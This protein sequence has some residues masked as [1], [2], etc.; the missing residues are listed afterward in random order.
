MAI[1]SW[2]IQV[3]NCAICRNHI[4]DMCIEC[5]ANPNAT[6]HEECAVAWGTCNVG[7]LCAM[8][9]RLVYSYAVHSRV[10]LFIARLSPALHFTL[11][12]DA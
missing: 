11:A 6:G 5:Q 8:A 2:D 7:K 3:D 10:H 9:R 1:W 4:M 12:Q